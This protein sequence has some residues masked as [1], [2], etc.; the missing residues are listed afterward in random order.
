MVAELSLHSP[1]VFRRYLAGGSDT[2][3]LSAPAGVVVAA[4]GIMLPELTMALS[5]FRGTAPT[6]MS[7][8]AAPIATATALLLAAIVARWLGSRLGATAGLTLLTSADFLMPGRDAWSDLAFCLVVT[9]ALGAVALGIAAG[10]L[11]TIERRWPRWIFY[12]AT[13]VALLLVGP[14]G[15]ALIGAVC[16]LFLLVSGDPRAARFFFDPVGLGLL[17][18]CGV[19]WMFWM[20]AVVSSGT[21]EG[22]VSFAALIDQIAVAGLPWTPVALLALVVGLRQGHYATP[23]WRLIGCWL[24]GPP[25]VALLISIPPKTVI[26]TV[27]PPLAVLGAAG[28]SSLAIW[29]RRRRLTAR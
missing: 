2:L 19:V 26:V 13:G 29:H 27:L 25:V 22:A 16:V 17:G 8:P 23:I 21:V 1:P 10:R 28:L 15:P 12:S 7:W 4:V 14:V 11:P 18:L 5:I 24:I 3:G 9:A 6:A 20:P